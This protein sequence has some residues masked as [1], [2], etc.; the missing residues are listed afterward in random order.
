MKHTIYNQ[1]KRIVSVGFAEKVVI[2]SFLLIYVLP[3]VFP[4]YTV[5]AAFIEELGSL[6]ETE[7]REPDEVRWVTVTAYSSTADQTDSTP[8]NTATGEHVYWGGV[9]TNSLA[10]NSQVRFIGYHDE[11]LFR[12]N[13]RMNRRF[14]DRI[15][16]WFPTRAEA[17]A[18]GKRRVEVQIWNY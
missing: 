16:I 10:I 1:I 3:W 18:W 15:D 14:S 12:V 8:F 7:M 9:A 17:I 5:E 13:D 6:P 4:Q 2:T 11:V